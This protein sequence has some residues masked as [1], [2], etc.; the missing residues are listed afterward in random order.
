[1]AR[2]FFDKHQHLRFWYACP[3]SNFTVVKQLNPAY[4]FL[5]HQLLPPWILDE[6]V[7]HTIKSPL[8]GEGGSISKS[9][10]YLIKRIFSRFK[11]YGSIQVLF[12]INSVS[13]YLSPVISGL[14]GYHWPF[15]RFAL[16]IFIVLLIAWFIIVERLVIE[17]PPYLYFH[18]NFS[19]DFNWC[20]RFGVVYDL[21]ATRSVMSKWYGK[22]SPEILMETKFCWGI[23]GMLSPNGVLIAG[24]IVEKLSYT[25]F[26]PSSL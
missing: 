12:F 18:F 11:R 16:G 7:W 23:E 17:T 5:C 21:A 6:C 3:R 4:E 25:I 2:D 26:G 20:S 14:P 10:T 19:R 24:P 22:E 13:I 15:S 1:M 8:D 9:V